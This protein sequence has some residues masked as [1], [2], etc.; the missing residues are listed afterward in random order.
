MSLNT[1]RSLGR[2]R[3]ELLYS[4]KNRG[5]CERTINEP[6]DL[7][8]FTEMFALQFSHRDD[9]L[10]SLHIE[11][12]N[13]SQRKKGP[14]PLRSKAVYESLYNILLPFAELPAGKQI[15]IGGF[16]TIDFVDMFDEMR[17]KHGSADTH[18]GGLVERYWDRALKM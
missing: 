2:I 1:L 17:K 4:T 15:T 11:L 13:E 12:L 14:K 8:D 5:D 6:R 18:C 9:A 3:L 7:E 16:D 10:Q